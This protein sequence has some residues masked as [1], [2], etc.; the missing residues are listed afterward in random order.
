MRQLFWSIL[1]VFLFSCNRKK[2]SVTDTYVYNS[3]G[4]SEGL[5]FSLLSV[6]GYD[7]DNLP[8]EYKD[9]LRVDLHYTG[10]GKVK[11]KIFFFEDND[12]YYWR[13]F[14]SKNEY[15][16]IPVPFKKD[17]WYG[18]WS[19]NFESGLFKTN[20]HNFFIFCDSVGQ[21]KIFEKIQQ[22]NL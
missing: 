7:K 16:T 19:S 18:L 12:N 15:K 10:K 14:V 6:Y 22:T 1:L 5:T 4:F 3:N 9:S 13:I 20:K 2:Y 21:L 8:N 17:N 11:K